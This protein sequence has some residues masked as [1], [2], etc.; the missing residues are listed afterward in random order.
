MFKVEPQFIDVELGEA[1]KKNFA[2]KRGRDGLCYHSEG[3]FPEDGSLLIGVAD[4]DGGKGDVVKCM[5]SGVAVPVFKG[6]P[7]AEA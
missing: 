3:W 5:I 7:H 1:V 2:L 4:E 6:A